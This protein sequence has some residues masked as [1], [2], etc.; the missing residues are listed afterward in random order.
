M[1]TDTIDIEDEDRYEILVPLGD[2]HYGYSRANIEKVKQVVAFIKEKDALV[3]GMGDYVDNTP[4][5]HPYFDQDKT[6]MTPQQQVFE[7]SKLF[8]PIKDRIL[9]LLYGNHEVR[10]IRSG[11]DPVE[12]IEELLDIPDKVRGAGSQRWFKI[13]TGKRIYTFFAVH[14]DA[15]GGYFSTAKGYKIRKM[16]RLHELADADIYLMGHLHDT[17]NTTREFIS[18]IRSTKKKWFIMTGGFVEYFGSYGERYGYTPV[19]TGCNAIYL[20]KVKRDVIIKRIV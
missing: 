4:P 7:I 1:T 5:T 14:G 6:D 8:K 2:I 20:D 9:F 15:R 11:Y 16:Y 10:S 18:G 19:E 13:N 3:V 12:Q 17:V